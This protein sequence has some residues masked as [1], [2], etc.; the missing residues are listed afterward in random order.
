[1]RG[2]LFRM[3]ED[4]KLTEADVKE[5]QS[6]VKQNKEKRKKGSGDNE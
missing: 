3:V 4:E 2:L 1:M 5:L 6:F